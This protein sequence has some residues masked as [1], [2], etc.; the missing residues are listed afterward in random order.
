MKKQKPQVTLHIPAGTT[1]SLDG[2]GGPRKSAPLKL[3]QTCSVCAL[4]IEEGTAVT[5]EMGP[6]WAERYHRACHPA[7]RGQ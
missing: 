7:T 5:V 3:N 4:A 1:L 2:L 6:G